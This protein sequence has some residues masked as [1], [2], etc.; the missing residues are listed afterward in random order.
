MLAACLHVG[1]RLGERLRTEF[2][3]PV[4]LTQRGETPR[5]SSPYRI[6]EPH[7]RRP[8]EEALSSVRGGRGSWVGGRACSSRAAATTSSHFGMFLS[9]TSIQSTQTRA[10]ECR[11]LQCC[12]RLAQN[13]AGDTW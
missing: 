12:A 7:V 9:A 3:E 2:S 1:R 10:R 11:W 6:V 5:P 4:M 13:R 8:N